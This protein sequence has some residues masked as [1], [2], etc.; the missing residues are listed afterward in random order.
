MAGAAAPKGVPMPTLLQVVEWLG[1]LLDAHV[2]GLATSTAAREVSNTLAAA[3]E[4]VHGFW[5]PFFPIELADAPFVR[6][7]CACDQ[8]LCQV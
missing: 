2:V 8:R 1:A 7:L 3:N 4:F 5:Q 6:L